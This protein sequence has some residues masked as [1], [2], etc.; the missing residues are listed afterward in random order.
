MT[1]MT[2][3]L[4]LTGAR[5]GKTCVLNGK[6]FVNGKCQL[7]GDPNNLKHVL[8]YMGRCYEAYPEGSD[9]LQLARA[10]DNNEDT[11]HGVDPSTSEAPESGAAAEVPGDRE[12][13]DSG[14][15]TDENAAQRSGDA[16]ADAGDSGVRSV[17]DG[18]EDT[19]V[20]TEGAGQEHGS[21]NNP[22][23]QGVIQ[24]LDPD[25]DENWTKTG[26]PAL[27]AV[28]KAYGSDVT[29]SDIKNAAPDWT[30]EK[31][32]EKALADI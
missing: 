23:L 26:L 14:A 8:T 30:R 18:H 17:G 9:E 22:R 24:S 3:T 16:G 25:L 4:V 6:R 31:A 19:R 21:G 28:Q 13:V 5:A 10:R 27:A 12:P 2:V 15:S 7:T 32:Q 1:A 11:T 20:S 29:R